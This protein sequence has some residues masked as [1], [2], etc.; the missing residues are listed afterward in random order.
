MIMMK[1]FFQPLCGIA[2]IAAVAAC[3]SGYVEPDPS[4]IDS[5]EDLQAY[6]TYSPERDII[7]SGHRGG[8][9][10]GYPENCIESCEKTLSLMPTFF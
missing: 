3:S 7:I 9:M 8:M 1:R 2:A 10:P 4:K 6:F 5:I